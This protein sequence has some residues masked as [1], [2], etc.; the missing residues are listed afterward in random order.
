MTLIPLFN[1][2]GGAGLF[3]ATLEKQVFNKKD[4]EGKG[5]NLHY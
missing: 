2:K 3:F 1:K 4:Q 5:S